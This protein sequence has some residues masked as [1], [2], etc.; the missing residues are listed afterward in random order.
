MYVLNTLAWTLDVGY[1]GTPVPAD[2]NY[3]YI[4]AIV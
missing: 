1:Q 2:L 4:K 3:A